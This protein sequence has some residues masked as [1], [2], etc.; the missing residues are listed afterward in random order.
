MRSATASTRSRALRRIQGI[1]QGKSR[2]KVLAQI[3]IGNHQEQA[4]LAGLSGL[5]KTAALENPRLT[6]QLILVPAQTTAEELAPAPAGR[7]A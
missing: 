4:L 5:L 6:G 2:G 7:E 1:L 3:V